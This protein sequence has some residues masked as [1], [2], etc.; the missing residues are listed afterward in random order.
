MHQSITLANG[1][2]QK[3]RQEVNQHDESRAPAGEE[4]LF[5]RGRRLK[6][7]KYR[8]KHPSEVLSASPQ[9]DN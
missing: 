7:Q 5:P 9:A 6:Y 8:F 4:D 3:Q 2:E 1:A